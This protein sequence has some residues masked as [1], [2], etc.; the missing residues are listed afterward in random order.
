[1]EFKKLISK[2]IKLQKRH[3][4]LLCSHKELIDSYVLLESAHKVM[5]TKVKDSKAHTYTYAPP[6]TD[7][8]CANSYCSQAKPTCDVHV[9]VETYNSFIASKNDELKRENEILNMELS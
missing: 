3:E 6:S 5:I 9:H 7:L 2:Y 4:D 1:V 8:S